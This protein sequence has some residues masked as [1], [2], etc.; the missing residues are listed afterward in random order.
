MWKEPRGPWKYT[1][2]ILCWVLLKKES[3]QGVEK[4]ST[5]SDENAST[6]VNFTYLV[7]HM[8]PVKEEMIS[9]YENYIAT[10]KVEKVDIWAGRDIDLTNENNLNPVLMAIWD[11]GVDA[12]NI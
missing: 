8:L 4:T 5:I 3:I 11:S 10:N 7:N 1:A 2:K 9:V 6:L 12:A